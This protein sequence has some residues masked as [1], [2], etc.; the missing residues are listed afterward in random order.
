M[1][2]VA[3]V[4][5]ALLAAAAEV[6]LAADPSALTTVPMEDRPI[7]RWWWPAGELDAAELGPSSRR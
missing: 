3:L 4:L 6:D 7:W 1:G 2:R 5:C